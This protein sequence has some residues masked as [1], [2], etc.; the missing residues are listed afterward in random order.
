MAN[1]PEKFQYYQ[2]LEREK[3]PKVYRSNCFFNSA[4]Q[5][6][7]S[8]SEFYKTQS[9]P[10]EKEIYPGIR[11]HEFFGAQIQIQR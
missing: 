4:S 8:S 1:A 5:K 10:K 3:N 9:P 2:A 6:N 11:F 7:S